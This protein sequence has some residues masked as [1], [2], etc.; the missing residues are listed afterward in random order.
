MEQQKVKKE[1]EKGGKKERKNHKLNFST[2]DVRFFRTRECWDI[3]PGFAVNRRDLCGLAG[4]SIVF[5]KIQGVSEI[6]K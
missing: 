1:K 4:G 5:K 3:I 2:I 6:R